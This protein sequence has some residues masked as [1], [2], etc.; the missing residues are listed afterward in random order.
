MNK[1][2]TH[3]SRYFQTTRYAVRVVA[4]GPFDDTLVDEL[5]RSVRRGLAVELIWSSSAA[6]WIRT[7]PFL[8]ARLF[9]LR[10]LGLEMNAL[11]ETESPAE[12]FWM[13]DFRTILVM[14]QNVENQ[15]FETI[16]SSQPDFASRKRKLDDWAALSTTFESDPKG[17]RIHFTA[18]DRTLRAGESTRLE[19]RVEGTRR[20]SLSGIGDVDP[21]GSYTLTIQAD[22]IIVLRAGDSEWVACKAVC[23]VARQ[24]VRIDYELEYLNPGTGAWYNLRAANIGDVYGISPNTR[25]RLRWQAPE[26]DQ[27]QVEPFG[28][29]GVTG[30]FIFQPEGLVEIN[31]IAALANGESSSR[32]II[33]REFPV[34]VFRNRFIQPSARFFPTSVFSWTDHRDR[35]SDWLRARGWLNHQRAAD[36]MRER[37]MKEHSSFSGQLDRSDFNA[38]Y[39]K[40]PVDRVNRSIFERLRNLILKKSESEHGKPKSKINHG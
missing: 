37:V 15:Y 40:H 17:I 8:M 32:R 30:E 12:W 28:L 16:E 21:I 2:I 14:T 33:I 10:N 25:V 1:I 38:F 9:R 3:I 31:L 34:P 19:W 36:R 20:V 29:S 23:I 22:T 26:A 4:A 39:M 6:A 5:Y 18:S 27:F 24:E 7:Q 11:P 13:F 35:A